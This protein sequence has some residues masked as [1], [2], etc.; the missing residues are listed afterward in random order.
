[1]SRQKGIFQLNNLVFLIL[2]ELVETMQ[3]PIKTVIFQIF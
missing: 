1:M 3:F 2:S